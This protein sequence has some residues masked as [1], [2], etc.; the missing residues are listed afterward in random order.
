[1]VYLL[2]GIAIVVIWFYRRKQKFTFL[3]VSDIREFKHQGD[4][5]D[6]TVLFESGSRK[7]RYH[8]TFKSTQQFDEAGILDLVKYTTKVFYQRHEGSQLIYT[9]IY[10]INGEEI[11]VVYYEVI[12]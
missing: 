5:Y 3:K 6:F 7:N 8:G 9:F 11:T 4:S 2:I 1:M 10:W 12:V